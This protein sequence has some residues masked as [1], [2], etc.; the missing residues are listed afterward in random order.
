MKKTIFLLL[1]AIP[2]CFLA[3][4]NFCEAGSAQGDSL[5]FSGCNPFESSCA[6]DYNAEIILIL[7][8]DNNAHETSWVVE[9]LTEGVI[10]GSGDSLV[11]DSTYLE[12]ICAYTDHCYRFII[13]DSE[14]NGIDTVGKAGYSIFWNGLLKNKGGDFGES[15]TT[16]FGSC[17]SDF[18]A[19]LVG[20]IPCVSYS[21]GQV[22]LSVSGGTPPFEYLWSDA[23]THTE[24]K[25]VSTSDNQVSVLVTDASNCTASDTFY[26]NDLKSLEIE[27]KSDPGASCIANSG[28]ASGSILSGIS[29]YTFSWSSGGNE[30]TEQ[31]LAPGTY[32]VTVT[33]AS[34]CQVVSN[35]TILESS[36]I[37][38]TI[39][40]II[41]AST[42]VN[43]GSI[44]ITT[45]GGA[46]EAYS[47]E[48]RNE[49][50]T[51]ISLEEDPSGLATGRYS[52]TVTDLNGCS[53]TSANLVTEVDDIPS[54][55]EFE[56]QISLIPNPTRG[57][58]LLSLN[59]Q[60]YHTVETRVYN[61]LGKEIIAMPPKDLQTGSFEFDLTQHP[62]GI[63]FFKISVDG[64]ALTKKVIFN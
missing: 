26:I 11:P 21:E 59:L 31:N 55:E 60:G 45:T 17:C 47:Y 18:S 49:W 4:Q 6:G 9:D 24:K 32:S 34:Q 5:G 2:S 43:N 62:T 40:S 41:H 57:K 27:L 15:D 46:G 54:H 51:V 56:N 13:F 38:V 50:N 52:V 7:K 44:H 10:V 29:P 36:P 8:T 48:W 28:E 63:Y 20:G 37:V 30:Q 64:Y 23:V 12:L 16:S 14:G 3:A 39:D 22:Q 1:F 42:T 35:V 19:E 58:V 25:S 61:D 53:V 33:D